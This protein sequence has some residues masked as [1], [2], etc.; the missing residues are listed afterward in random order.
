[1][2]AKYHTEN[3]AM[4]TGLT[5]ECTPTTHLEQYRPDDTVIRARCALCQENEVGSEIIKMICL[6]QKC[7]KNPIHRCR[8]EN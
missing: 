2:F 3:I 8:M 7:Q 4:V 1:M 6:A 5:C